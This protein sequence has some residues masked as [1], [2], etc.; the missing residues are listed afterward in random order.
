MKIFTQYAL[1]FLYL[2]WTAVS[3]GE[4]TVLIE[5]ENFNKTGGWVIDQQSMDQMGSPYLLAHGLGNPVADAVTMLEFPQIG[6]Y[7]IWVRTRDWVAPWKKLDTP[8]V[9]L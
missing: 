8:A 3:L 9:C 4:T 7:R 1:F 6:E 5:A 2:I